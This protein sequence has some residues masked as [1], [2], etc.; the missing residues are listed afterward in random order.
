HS[1]PRRLDATVDGAVFSQA[2]D[3]IR[4]ATVTGVQT[5]ALPICAD[6]RWGE[7]ARSA[8][9]SLR[10]P[11]LAGGPHGA[12]R[13]ARSPRQPALA[14]ALE[15]GRASC[16]GSVWSGGGAGICS[17]QRGLLEERAGA[18]TAAHV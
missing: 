9:S 17:V 15:I 12:P 13:R 11:H 1:V 10:R 8:R 7:R 6:R 4:D 16:R 5:C 2:E 18:P 14:R 3:G